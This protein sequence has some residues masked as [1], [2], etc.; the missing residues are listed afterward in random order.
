[1]ARAAGCKAWGMWGENEAAH[2]GGR[3]SGLPQRFGLLRGA[4]AKVNRRR[5]SRR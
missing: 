4:G 3:A 1:M 5:Q 2:E